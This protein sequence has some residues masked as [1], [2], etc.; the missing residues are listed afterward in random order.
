LSLLLS[1]LGTQPPGIL[2][3]ALAFYNYLDYFTPIE[4]IDNR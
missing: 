1:A 3:A 2:G 4:S